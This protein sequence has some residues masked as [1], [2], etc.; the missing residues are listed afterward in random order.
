MVK[1]VDRVARLVTT[2][3]TILNKTYMLT[4]NNIM[5]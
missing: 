5:R 2:E 3:I 1:S 4:I